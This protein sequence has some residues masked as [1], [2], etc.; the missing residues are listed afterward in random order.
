MQQYK[1]TAEEIKQALSNWPAMLKKYS[2]ASTRKALLQILTSFGPFIAIW[3]VMYFSLQVSYWL[4]LGL[5][6]HQRL[7]SRPY[8]YHPA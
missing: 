3:V 6:G 1:Y 2:V 4:T 8:F 5:G 7:F